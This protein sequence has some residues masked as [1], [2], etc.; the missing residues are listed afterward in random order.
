MVLKMYHGIWVVM[1]VGGF[2]LDVPSDVIRF[3]DQVAVITVI[4]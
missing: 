1:Q 3:N 4:A 2:T